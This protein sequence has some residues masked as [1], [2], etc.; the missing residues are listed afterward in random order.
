MKIR[1][2]GTREE[3]TAAAELLA[4]VLDVREVSAFYPNRGPSVLGRV[5]LD[6]APPAARLQGT[7][8]RT[9]QAPQGALQ[10]GRRAKR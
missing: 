8:E 4:T 2:T 9:D 7:A 10:P 5:Y 1:V 3:C 6:A